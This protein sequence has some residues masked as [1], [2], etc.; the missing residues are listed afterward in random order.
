MYVTFE[1]R[2]PDAVVRLTSNTDARALTMFPI[3]VAFDPSQRW[4]LTASK[5]GYCPI[6]LDVDY[7]K[8]TIVIEL[9][10]GCKS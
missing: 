3:R 2:T 7:T 9:H 10:A 4:T 8:P 1:L 6:R 5:P